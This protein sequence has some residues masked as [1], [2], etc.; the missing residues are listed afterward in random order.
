MK[1]DASVFG[2]KTQGRVKA[3]HQT[4]TPVLAEHARQFNPYRARD[5]PVSDYPK[6]VGKRHSEESRDGVQRH[7]RALFGYAEFVTG[8]YQIPQ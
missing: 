8:R 1:G 4:D 2:N 7:V 6:R 5:R 3:R